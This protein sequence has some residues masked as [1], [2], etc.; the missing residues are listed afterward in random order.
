MERLHKVVASAGVCSRR[1][2]ERLMLEGRVRVNGHVVTRPG[3]QVDPSRDSIAV[4][5]KRLPKTSR[6]PIYLMLNKP[7]NCV[8]TLADPQGRLSV[9]DLI[10]TVRSRVFPVGRLDFDSEGLLLVTNDGELARDLMHP[11]TGVE[12]TYT[13]K[14]RGQPDEKALRRLGRGISLDGRRASSSR[15]RRV[16]GSASSANSW[17]EVTVVEG[18]KHMV[19]RMLQSVGHPVLKLRRTRYD[20]IRLGKLPLGKFRHLTQ[21][22]LSGLRQACQAAGRAAVRK[23]ARP[24]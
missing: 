5:G 17:L 19:R 1:A 15:L 4:D 9:G 8:T 6:Q 10:R 18:R 20:G 14:V 24:T 11:G 3:S 2:A 23:V 7:R 16:K 21:R 13:V 12:K 22:E